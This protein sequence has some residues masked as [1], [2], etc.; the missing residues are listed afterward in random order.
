MNRDIDQFLG[1]LRSA[2]LDA[3]EISGSSHGSYAWRNHE[4]LWYPDF[5]LCDERPAPQQYDV[6]LCE[7]VL[8]HVVDPAAAV[9]K[10]RAL[11]RPGGHIVVSTP[12]LLRIHK[13]PADY[14]RFSADGL[15]ALL[16]HGGMTDVRVRS[17][18]NRSC[19]R[20]NFTYW[21]PYRPWHSLTNEPNY[22]VVVWAY[23]RPT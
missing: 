22:P 2:D 21:K 11:C 23:G 5:D 3:V 9:R 16:E 8:E 1:E 15:R 10:L 14:W 4:S 7:Q 17:W 18:G 19:V 13:E 12:F 6:V 20:H